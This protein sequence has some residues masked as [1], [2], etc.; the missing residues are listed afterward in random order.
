MAKT[1]YNELD[2]TAAVARLRALE[3]RLLTAAD[4]EKLLNSPSAEDTVK[5][6]GSLGWK[7]ADDYEEMLDSELAG[8]FDLI[9][10]LG[11]GSFLKT[12]RIKYDYHNLKALIKCELTKQSCDD[13]LINFG[14]IKVSNM[15]STVLNRDYHTLTDAMRAALPQAYEQYARVNDVQLVDMIL[16]SAMFADMLKF[17][18]TQ[19]ENKI[20]DLIRLQIDMHNIKTFVRVR[21][22]NKVFGFVENALADGGTIPLSF[23]INQINLKAE[24]EGSIFERTPYAKAF[25]QGA[26]IEFALD[27]IF[28]EKVKSARL[29]AFGLAPVAAYFWMKEN[30]IRN[31]RII[32][33]CKR[34][35]IG[36]EAIRRR[37]RG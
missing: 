5:Q 31:V 10:S 33:T 2:Y 37:L 7:T 1:T 25:A 34:A 11:G 32:L 19:P 22:M 27:N 13:L 24:S 9:E 8:V 16:D 36:I 29:G 21:K 17:A 15:K 6:L 20:L 23:F 35:G 30:E 28:M 14:I 4:Y 26:D 18:E 12:Q 3:T